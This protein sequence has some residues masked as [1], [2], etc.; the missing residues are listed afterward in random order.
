MS[1]FHF[2]TFIHPILGYER[3]PR[4]VQVLILRLH[5]NDFT[6]VENVLGVLPEIL[7]PLLM[8]TWSSISSSWNNF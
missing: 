5:E 3:R 7:L 2:T 1:F 4:N 8:A 6:S